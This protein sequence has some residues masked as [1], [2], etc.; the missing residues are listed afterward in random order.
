M[1][2]EF[3][4]KTLEENGI[5]DASYSDSDFTGV[6]SWSS[7]DD[8]ENAL[9]DIRDKIKILPGMGYDKGSLIFPKE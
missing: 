5:L 4:I 3:I 2:A 6:I 7:I 9:K 8:I 1:N